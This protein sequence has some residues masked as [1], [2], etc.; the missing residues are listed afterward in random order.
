[1]PHAHVQKAYLAEAVHWDVSAS[2]Q[3]AC[4]TLCS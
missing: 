2:M 3:D 4:E 1:M